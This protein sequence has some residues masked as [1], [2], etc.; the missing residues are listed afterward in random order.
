MLGL[1]LAEGLSLSMLID[2]FGQ[3]TVDRI[4]HCLQPYWWRGWV[5]IARSDGSTVTL[6]DG[7]TL[8]ISGA[9]LGNLRLSDPEGFLFS[10]QILAD[11]F[12][13]LEIDS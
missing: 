5:E 7:E 4:W 2:K 9:V 8:A 13:E 11:L 10:N 6:K 3:Q 12:S 1:R